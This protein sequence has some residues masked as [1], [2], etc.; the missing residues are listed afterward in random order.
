V[1]SRRTGPHGP[2]RP[3]KDPLKA[4]VAEGGGQETIGH[5][6]HRRGALCQLSG[7]RGSAAEGGG[8]VLGR[9]SLVLDTDGRRQ[10]QTE[11]GR[12]VALDQDG[13]VVLEMDGTHGLISQA[14]VDAL[15][16]AE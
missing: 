14:R 5:H 8:I 3:W 10:A 9:T 15:V 12:P 6:R 13:C 1:D 7:R 4:I 2:L 11:R 16:E